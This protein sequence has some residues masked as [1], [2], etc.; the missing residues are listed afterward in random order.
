[1]KTFNKLYK[2]P[3]STCFSFRG[4][5]FAISQIHFEINKKTTTHKIRE[6]NT[7][8]VANNNELANEQKKINNI[9]CTHCQ[10]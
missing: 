5:F 10:C 6:K 2:I 8:I 4:V 3:L 9:L 7:G 1:M